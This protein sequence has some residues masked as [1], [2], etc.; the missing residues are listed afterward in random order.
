MHYLLAALLLTTPAAAVG[1]GYAPTF[2]RT[3][4]EVMEDLDRMQRGL[5]TDPRQIELKPPPDPP[6]ARVAQVARDICQRHG[7]RKVM[8]GRYKW[9]CR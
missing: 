4:A 6:K 5:P 8:V 7:K 9:R 3:W 2:N 1:Q